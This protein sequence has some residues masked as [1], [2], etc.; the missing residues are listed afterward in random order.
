MRLNMR[1]IRKKIQKAYLSYKR[2][3][4]FNPKGRFQLVPNAYYCTLE[5]ERGFIL[6]SFRPYA[7]W[8]QARAAAKRIDRR[9]FI[10]LGSTITKKLKTDGSNG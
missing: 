4:N 9:A 2:T 7:R 3:G 10:Q 1:N 6:L 5:S 8:K